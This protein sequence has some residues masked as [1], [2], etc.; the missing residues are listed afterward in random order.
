MIPIH[1]K[2]PSLECFRAVPV[3][4]FWKFARIRSALVS[5]FLFS[6]LKLLLVVSAR[7]P[8]TLYFEVYFCESKPTIPSLVCLALPCSWCCCVLF[9]V[10]CS[11]LFLLF[12][13]N[14]NVF[15]TLAPSVQV[16]VE[17]SQVLYLLFLWQV[18]PLF[19]NFRETGAAPATAITASGGGLVHTGMTKGCVGAIDVAGKNTFANFCFVF[20]WSV[21][22][23]K[24]KILRDGRSKGKVSVR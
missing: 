24:K 4:G 19:E 13:A 14:V 20:L 16:V 17:G 10:L 8:R 5:P 12:P 22:E 6:L 7:H 18:Y 23:M 21:A 9:S 2:V 15:T 1:D 3:L 11:R